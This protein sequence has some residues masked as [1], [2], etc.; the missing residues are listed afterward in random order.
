MYQHFMLPEEEKMV[1]YC[2]EQKASP[3]KAFEH[4]SFYLPAETVK[5]KCHLQFESKSIVDWQI[6]DAS[7]TIGDGLNSVEKTVVAEDTEEEE[8]TETTDPTVVLQIVDEMENLHVNE[9][10]STANKQIVIDE[11]VGSVAGNLLGKY[12]WIRCAQTDQKKLSAAH[13]R[14]D[15]R[16]ALEALEATG[17]SLLMRVLPIEDCLR[18]DSSL[19]EEIRADAVHKVSSL[20]KQK[21]KI[22]GKRPGSNDSLMPDA[23][24]RA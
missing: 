21:S 22:L 4:H 3:Y 12:R 19:L 13:A 14:S 1:R 15:G 23:G 7:G 10:K 8:C 9:G 2:V 16:L 17:R 5:V 20:P 18:F 6:V 11:Q 24:C